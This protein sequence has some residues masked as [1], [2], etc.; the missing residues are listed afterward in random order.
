MQSKRHTFINFKTTDSTGINKMHMK[1]AAF[2]KHDKP[3]LDLFFFALIISGVDILEK[4]DKRWR[5][6]R[7]GM[8]FVFY[9]ASIVGLITGAFHFGFFLDGFDK[10]SF[11]PIIFCYSGVLL[12][13]VLHL[14]RDDFRQILQTLS[15]SKYDME[16]KRNY[17][18]NK[19]RKIYIII[20][21]IYLIILLILFTI[22]IYFSVTAAD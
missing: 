21:S 3:L 4:D 1:S 20:L 22:S 19:K 7:F 13:F 18:L 5:V 8:T 11:S 14:K 6:V 12:S 16:R 10:D 15:K 2:R 17:T 9:I